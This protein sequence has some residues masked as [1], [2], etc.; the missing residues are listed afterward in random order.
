MSLHVQG[1]TEGAEKLWQEFHIPKQEKISIQT[2][3]RKHLIRGLELKEY[4]Y[5]KCSECSP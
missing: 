4:I 2:Y 3:I 5:N 1:V